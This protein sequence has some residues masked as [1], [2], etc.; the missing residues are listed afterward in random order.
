[1]KMSLEMIS[2]LPPLRIYFGDKDPLYDDG[3]R[4]FAM[5]LS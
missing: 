3:L 5:A 4:Y 2:K 1:M